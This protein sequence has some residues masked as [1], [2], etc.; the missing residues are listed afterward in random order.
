MP[1]N[2]LTESDLILAAVTRW[3]PPQR[4]AV[5][6]NVY[7]G[8]GL[9]YE[10]DAIAVSKSG[11]VHELEA[12]CV[13]SDLLRDPQKRRWQRPAEVDYHW[14]VIP[15]ALRAEAVEIAARTGSGVLVVSPPE[16]GD[17]IGRCKRIRLPRRLR[18]HTQYIALH[19]RDAR[20]RI[21]RLCS[22]RYWTDRIRNGS[23]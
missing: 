2:A 14:Y 3:F 12:K 15:E 19:N 5:C 22:L 4:W 23:E 8:F 16:D 10:A 1:R 17:Q 6:P 11:R 13:K 9:P 18:D 7:Y 21:W 20:N